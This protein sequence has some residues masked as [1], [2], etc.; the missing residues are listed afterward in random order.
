VVQHCW[1]CTNLVQHYGVV[2]VIN[3]GL[4]G[5]EEQVT[6]DRVGC[7]YFGLSHGDGTSW[8]LVYF[9]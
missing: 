9:I 5:A 1:L 8:A 7:H 4:Y 3:V 2:F 6:E